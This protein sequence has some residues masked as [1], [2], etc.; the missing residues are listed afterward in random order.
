MSLTKLVL[1][2]SLIGSCWSAAITDHPPV[3]LCA[4]EISAKCPAENGETPIYFPD[5]DD[6]SKFCE[7]CCGDAYDYSCPS[8][9]YWD[10]HLNICNWPNQVECESRPEPPSEI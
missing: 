8:G 10:T 1:I 9:L 3:A 6:C 4:P 5:P 7:C 2:V